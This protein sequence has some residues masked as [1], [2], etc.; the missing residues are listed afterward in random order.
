[1]V[2]GGLMLK[3]VI[4]FLVGFFCV[5]IGFGTAFVD[6]W[7][8]PFTLPP[9]YILSDKEQWSLLGPIYLVIGLSV[10]I[11]LFA[12]GNIMSPFLSVVRI[13]KNHF[14]PSS[15]ELDEEKART[16]SVLV[17]KD[18]NARANFNSPKFQAAFERILHQLRNCEPRK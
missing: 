18:G 4:L 15:M 2:F 14:T 6:G 16:A 1:M 5:F 12:V 13:V 10:W 17:D 9:D 11:W 7:I 8:N 3:N